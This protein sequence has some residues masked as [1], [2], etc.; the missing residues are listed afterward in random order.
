MYIP[1]KP[2]VCSVKWKRHHGG[3][4]NPGWLKAQL[5]V[6]LWDA[7]PVWTDSFLNKSTVCEQQIKYLPLF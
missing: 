1:L 5:L 2:P 7:A 4:T 6:G 3:R